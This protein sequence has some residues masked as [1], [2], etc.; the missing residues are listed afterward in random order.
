[1]SKEENCWGC[2]NIDQESFPFGHS[3]D[4]E[5]KILK[6]HAIDVEGCGMFDTNDYTWLEILFCP[7]C[8]KKL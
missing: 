6:K 7:V 3:E 1:M 4:S 2:I 8:G 5:D